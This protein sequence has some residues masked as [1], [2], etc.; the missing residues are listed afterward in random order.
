[1]S[2][3]EMNM[4]TR[5]RVTIEYDLDLEQDAVATPEI[6]AKEL[7]DWIDG[8]VEV[9]DVVVCEGVEAVTISVV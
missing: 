4:A 2:P 8:H 7:Q 6:L 3:M 5:V 1:M 9:A